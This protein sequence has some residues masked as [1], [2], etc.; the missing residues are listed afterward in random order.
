MVEAYAKSFSYWDCDNYGEKY[1]RNSNSSSAR[2]ISNSRSNKTYKYPHDSKDRYAWM[3]A[4]CCL[5]CLACLY[6]FFNCDYGF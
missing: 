6:Y 5:A 3:K 2:I 1:K 4:L